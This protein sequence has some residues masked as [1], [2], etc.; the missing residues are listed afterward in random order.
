[1]ELLT[2]EQLIVGHWYKLEDGNP[3]FELVA[4]DEM[5]RCIEVQ[6]FDGT[7]NEFEM[8][9]A[10]LSGIARCASPVNMAGALD[11]HD[12]S[13]RSPLQGDGAWH[14]SLVDQL[15][16]EALNSEI[17]VS[18]TAGDFDRWTKEWA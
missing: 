3:P 9:T 5:E 10:L 1:M 13:D 8:T 12:S 15:D 18:G 14:D 11:G 16:R 7:I 2:H 6:Y 17:A 4:I